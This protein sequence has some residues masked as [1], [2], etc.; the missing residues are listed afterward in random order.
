MARG[1]G[2]RIDHVFSSSAS[3]CLDWPPG[4]AVSLTASRRLWSHVQYACQ[5]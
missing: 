4:I 3:P 2:C 1:H 5:T